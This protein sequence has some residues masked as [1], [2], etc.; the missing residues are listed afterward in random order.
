MLRSASTAALDDHTAAKRPRRR[1]PLSVDYVRRANP[2]LDDVQGARAHLALTVG[3]ADAALE[4]GG[5]WHD[6][7]A[8][9]SPLR[10]LDEAAASLATGSGVGPP[11]VRRGS[12]VPRTRLM[13][14]TFDESPGFLAVAL[15][16]GFFCF[17]SE[18]SLPG[19]QPIQERGM[20]NLE[21]AGPALEPS[22][23]EAGGRIVLDL[24]PGSG[25]SLVVGKRSIKTVREKPSAVSSS[26]SFGI[27]EPLPA[28]GSFCYELTVNRAFAHSWDTI[29]QA[30]GVDWLGFN[31]VRA[32]YHALHG[33]IPPPWDPVGSEFPPDAPR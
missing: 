8:I 27:G 10:A 18:F 3:I 19:G 29:V 14:Y 13:L 15:R 24:A 2:E 31:R 5:C 6:S 1:R 12:T 4:C 28:G 30:H 26:T 7:D 23:E 32:A 17:G 22:G 33:R 25:Q 21:L 20:L 9:G 11:I 16:A